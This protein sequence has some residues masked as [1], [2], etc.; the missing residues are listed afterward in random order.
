MTAPL[1]NSEK[2]TRMSQHISGTSR[3]AKLPSWLCIGL[4]MDDQE[5]FAPSFD[6]YAFDNVLVEM[7][8]IPAKAPPTVKDV[9]KQSVHNKNKDA[10]TWPIIRF[11]FFFH[12]EKTYIQVRQMHHLMGFVT[13]TTNRDFVRGTIGTVPFYCRFSMQEGW[14]DGCVTYYP[15]AQASAQKAVKFFE[16]T[17]WEDDI[18][19]YEV[20]YEPDW[21]A[22]YYQSLNKKTS[23]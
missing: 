7:D 19:A 2:K 21:V 23:V 10:A 20:K 13:S 14:Y 12:M 15:V 17:D 8:T 3:G 4:D 9:L 5:A 11:K 1:S 18:E 22:I 16:S 6:I